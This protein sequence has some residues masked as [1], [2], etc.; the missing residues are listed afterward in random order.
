MA[1][2]NDAIVVAESSLMGGDSVFGGMRSPAGKR[3]NLDFTLAS[4]NL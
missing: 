1:G 2:Q 4:R 3:L